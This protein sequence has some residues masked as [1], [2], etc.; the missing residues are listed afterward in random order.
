MQNVLNIT[1]SIDPFE[2]L[3]TLCLIGNAEDL[4]RYCTQWRMDREIEWYKTDRYDCNFQNQQYVFNVVLHDIIS[5]CD[6][7]TLMLFSRFIDLSIL[8]S[9]MQ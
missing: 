5:W 6:Y 7:D 9:M 4:H 8:L 3:R 2:T 1:G